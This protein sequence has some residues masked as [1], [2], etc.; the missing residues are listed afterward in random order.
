[1]G[2][3]GPEMATP[4]ETGWFVLCLPVTNLQVALEFYERLG[5]RLTGGQPEQGWAVVGG[6]NC[7]LNPMRGLPQPLMNFRGGDTPALAE[8]LRQRGLEVRSFNLFD[9]AKY[10]EAYST[11]ERGNA[12]PS[13]GSG[14]FT[15]IDPEGRGVYFDTVPRERALLEKG[16]RWTT[17]TLTGRWEEGQLP[18]GRFTYALK[19]SDLDA[20]RAFYERLD[21]R[22]SMDDGDRGCVRMDSG[23]GR[24]TLSLYLEL[25]CDRAVLFHGVD[26]DVLALE[27]EARG[28]TID[29]RPG[30]GGGDALWLTDPDGHVL[31]FSGP[32][33]Q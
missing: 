4:L 30:P 2:S 13:E 19:A 16:Q 12:L 3:K 17:S 26:L 7:E 6:G 14:D 11:D 1:M 32:A 18:L 8:A 31:I 20:S 22:V 27:L 25:S 23:D 29:R 10:P 28:L 21:F 9:P 33:N 5:F 15:V 24:C